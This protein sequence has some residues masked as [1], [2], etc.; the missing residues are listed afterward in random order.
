MTFAVPRTWSLVAWW[1][2]SPPP[3]LPPA[4][5]A[6]A[7]TARAAAPTPSSPEWTVGPC[8]RAPSTRRARRRA[9]RAPTDDAGEALEAAIDRELV[10]AEAQRLGLVADAAEVER[11]WPLWARQL[12]GDAAL[13][14]AREGGHE[15]GSA[16]REPARR[17][18]AQG[19]PGRAL[20]AGEGRT[21][22][23][24]R[25]YERRRA[26]LFTT[27]AAVKLGAIVARNEGIAGNAVKRLRQGRP[28]EEVS[29]Q[30]SVDPE[31]KNAGGAIG[32]IDPRSMPEPL[33]RA[34]GRLRVGGD[35]HDRSPDQVAPGSSGPGAPAATRGA[36]RQCA[37]DQIQDALTGR[38]RAAALDKW[39]ATAR[40]DALIE[41]L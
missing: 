29:R 26:D 34:V 41:R 36:V 9:S 25:F 35:L 6:A 38:R 39:L 17:R 22:A 10:R 1:R 14:A 40:K 18:A 11:A 31:L 8:T 28:F 5:A 20:S 13:K 19:R 32:W 33:R 37:R 7:A 4:A 16:P 21:A 15:R 12:G 23:A 2:S 30:F 24:R 27:A 3:V